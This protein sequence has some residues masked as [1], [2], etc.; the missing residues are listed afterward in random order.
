MLDNGDD[1]EAPDEV[2][3]N[4]GVDVVGWDDAYPRTRF[5]AAS[6]QPPGDGAFLVRNSY[7]ASYGDDGYF[8]VS[9]HD[10]AFAFGPLTSYTRVDERE[11]L[12][13]QLPV[14]HASAGP[15]PSG[16]PD[17][18]APNEAWGAN[19]FVAK[20]TERIAAAGFYVPAAGAA[21]RGVGRDRRWPGSACAPRGRR[22]CRASRRWTSST[23]LA[24]R[25]GASFVVAL[26]VVTPD[27]TEPIA[28]ESRSWEGEP[29]A[30]LSHA[31]AKAGQSYMRNTDGDAWLDLALD[32][33]TAGVNVCLKAYAR[34]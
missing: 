1:V 9:Y 33:D 29:Q 5:A 11:Q 27:G 34:K 28:V 8:W 6:G 23:P 12:R 4:H 3:E 21:V 2:P 10:R 18:A 30:W 22:P 7:G 24:V 14:R 17:G 25:K 26:R 19:R 15:S 31:G 20:A 32:G 13:A 16:T